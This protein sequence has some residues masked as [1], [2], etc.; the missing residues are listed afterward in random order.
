MKKNWLIFIIFLFLTSCNSSS[1][2]PVGVASYDEILTIATTIHRTG[3]TSLLL[4][5]TETQG[6]PKKKYKQTLDNLQNY[7][8]LPEGMKVKKVSTLSQKEYDPMSFMPKDWPD[9]FKQR[10][11]I[12]RWNITPDRYIIITIEPK[13][14]QEDTEVR[15][16]FGV[17]EEDNQWYFAASY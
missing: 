8:G 4:K 11:A 12:P 7:K 14:P 9:E 5:H 15:S 3:D 2:K 13:E 10:F 16:V 6:I 1:N 17:Y